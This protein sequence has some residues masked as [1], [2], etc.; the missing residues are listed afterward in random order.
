MGLFDRF[1]GKGNDFQTAC[2]IM[3]TEFLELYLNE[4]NSLFENIT[5]LERQILAVYFFGMSDGLRQDLATNSNVNEIAN[6]IINIM[7]KDFKY[8]KEQAE[9]FFDKMIN[10]LQSNNP[11]NTHYAIIHNG[12]DGYFKWQK[13]NKNEVINDICKIIDILKK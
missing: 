2:K 8:S 5:E 11:N 9:Q 7:I 6:I 3:G 4:T 10:N 1:K 12:L 13:N